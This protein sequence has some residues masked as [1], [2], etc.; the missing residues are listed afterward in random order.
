[1]KTEI[2]LKR[3]YFSQLPT[4]I[5][6]NDEFTVKLFCYPSGVEAVELSNSRG[7][8]IVLP[9]MGQIV[10]YAEFDGI[11][12]TMKNMFSQPR[13]THNMLDTYGCFAFHSGL[14]ASGCPSPEDTH[15]MHGEFCCADM[16]KAW[17]EIDGDSVS[18]CGEY[19]Y[20]QGFGFRY[21]AR[22][23][24]NLKAKEGRMTINMQMK[25]TTSVPMPLQY[26][27]HINYA[28]VDKGE[29]TANIPDRAFKLRE[30]IPSHIK[31]TQEWFAYTDEIKKMQAEGKTLTKLGN[32]DLYNT[33]IVFL[34][35]DIDEYAEYAE[36]EI[37]SPKG[38][39]FKTKFSTRQFKHAIRWIM[40]NGDQQVSSFIIPATS[41][42]EGFLAA[43]KAGHLI[44]LQPDETKDF[45][46]TTGLE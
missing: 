28:Y 34:A 2:L 6:Q 44:M 27:C 8:I 10:W 20:C 42:P 9:Y 22:P 3:E 21:T 16:D 25:N 14:L 15:A 39:S 41:R 11:N 12:L 37:H 40:Y 5:L 46:V 13:R 1:M 38:Y 30:T 24:V 32:P 33:E 29:F 4:K 35:D 36:A 19:E 23:S 17:L 31:P 7:R 26:I 43:K 45:S 18:V